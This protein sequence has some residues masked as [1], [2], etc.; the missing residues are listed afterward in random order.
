[1]KKAG[2]NGLKS[3]VCGAVLVAAT[4][5]ATGTRLHAQIPAYEGKSPSIVSK[6]KQTAVLGGGCFWGVEAVFR[7]ING[8]KTVTAGYSGGTAASAK[9][10]VVSS[11]KT[12]H[13]ESVKITY[14]PSQVSYDQLLRVFFS[15]AHNPT[16]L[17]RQGPDQGTQY[18]SVIFYADEDQKQVALA[19][20]N[21]LNKAR[22]FAGPIV[23][24]VVP[25][26][27]FY[28][29]EAYHQDYLEHHPD[30]PYIVV[31]DLPKVQKLKKEYPALCKR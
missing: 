8:V 18:R 9:Y 22:V 30:N 11:G 15:V 20:I 27:A 25:L 13:A 31:N 29:A 21:Q 23:T 24:Q 3:R 17:N 28:P 14:D 7:R 6:G 26:K 19:Y 5:C 1:M 12:G 16:E 4:G 10:E 2:T